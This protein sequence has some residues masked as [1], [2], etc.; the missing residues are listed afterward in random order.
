MADKSDVLSRPVQYV[1]GVGPV[2]ARLLARLGIVTVRDL[3]YFFPR[4]HEDRTLFTAV[5]AVRSNDRVTICGVVRDVVETRSRNNMTITR[6]A[7]S[8]GSGTAWGVWFNQPYMKEKFR[9]GMRVALSGRV[10]FRYGRK[11]FNSPD[12]EEMD[13]DSPIHAGRMVPVYA[14][15]EG[16]SQRWLR[17]TMKYVVES[18]APLV[19]EVLPEETVK[20]YK[21]PSAGE[22]VRAF[23][24]PSGPEELERARRRL[25]FEELFLMQLGVVSFKRQ[26]S[27]TKG[28][29][30]KPDPPLVEQLVASLPFQLTRAQKRVWDEI[31]RDMEGPFP[32]NRLLQGDVGSGKT[33]I[34]AMAIA[35]CVQSG[36]QAALMAP[37][38]ILAE[39]HFN[40]LRAF[41]CPLGVR[42]RLLTSSTGAKE[43]AEVLEG[44]AEGSV[45][46]AVGT[47]SLLEEGVVFRQL[48]LAITDEQHRFGVRQRARLMSKGASPDTLVMTATP[49]PRTLAL[50]L[51]GD[52]DISVIDEMPPGRRP[53]E[54]AWFPPSKRGQIYR[55][56]REQL[57]RGEQA[58][59]VCPLVEESDAVEAAAAVD[60]AEEL[61]EKWLSDVA[62]GVLHGKMK[63]AEKREVLSAF[64]KGKLAVLVSTTVVEVGIDVPNATILVVEGAERFGL[65]ELHQLRGRVGR[66]SKQSYC[67]LIADPKSEVARARLEVITRTHSGFE[68]AEEDLKLRGPGEFLGTRQHGEIQFRVADLGKDLDLLV[69]ARKEAERVLQRDPTLASHA[70]LRQ[71]LEQRLWDR[72][73]FATVG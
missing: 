7:V 26:N 59:V 55:W 14:L 36:Y 2:R 5:A 73:P 23:H 49:I 19:D 35:K 22:A 29:S 72:L 43:R 38:E 11:E 32:M 56:L 4:R 17:E 46:V 15:T 3:I 30:H 45:D 8:D 68:I 67:L 50:T 37:T 66:G 57:S 54:T 60:L 24:F 48:A 18:F 33:V 63:S 40:T 41:L 61:K 9:V 71:V 21:F 13:G 20:K 53:V 12:F 39:Q 42:V 10:T 52:L 47:H 28:Y 64:K 31:R 25:A 69:A 34:A 62:I 65:A 27:L 58:Y 1:K 16:L 44:L 51:Y 70:R 6:V